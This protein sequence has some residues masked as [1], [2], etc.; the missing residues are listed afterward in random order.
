MTISNMHTLCRVY[1]RAKLDPRLFEEERR[2]WTPSERTWRAAGWAPILPRRT[3]CAAGGSWDGV[4]KVQEKGRVDVT[5]TVSWRG[6]PGLAGA[7]QYLNSVLFSAL[8]LVSPRVLCGCLT[9]RL[10]RLSYLAPECGRGRGLEAGGDSFPGA[11]CSP[12]P[13]AVVLADRGPG[14]HVSSAQ[15]S[16]LVSVCVRSWKE[17][18]GGGARRGA[19]PEH[20]RGLLVCPALTYSLRTA[21]LSSTSPVPPPGH[22]PPRLPSDGLF[23]WRCL[24]ARGKRPMA[25]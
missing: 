3:G 21:E 1:Y 6:P 2:D 10:V 12:S 23:L 25:H 14:V 24:D 15:A 13:A 9:L 19:G 22:L 5:D 7:P 18:R 16:P 17:G 8:C 11:A 20:L 4:Q